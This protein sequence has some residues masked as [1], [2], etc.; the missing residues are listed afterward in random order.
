[1]ADPNITYALDGQVALIGLDRPA[2]RNALSDALI[3]ELRVAVER[4]GVEAKAGVIFGHGDHFSAGLDLAEHVHRTPIENVHHS[5]N[6]HAIFE[7][8]ER[9]VIPFVCAIHGAAVGGGIE[10][11]ASCQIRVA[12][13][14]A[15]FA[16]PEGQ[17]GIFVGGGGSVRIARLISAA[18][19]SDMMLTGRVLSAAEAERVNLVQY[20]VAPGAGLAKAKELAAR[21]AG[22]SPM[23]N[24]AVTHALSRIQDLSHDDGLFFESLMAAMTQTTPEA[25]ERLQ[26]FLDKRA[27]RIAAPGD[28]SGKP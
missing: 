22:N 19:M 18:R 7:R 21:I 4:A 20:V 16:L 1:M 10:L 5:R 23:A 9:G 24:F 3:E 27:E 17:R 6:W 26:A 2:K 11:A 28:P 14:G 13:E 12:E 15:F 8:I 25:I